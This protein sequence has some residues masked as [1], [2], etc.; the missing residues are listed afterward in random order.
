MKMFTKILIAV[1]IIIAIPM[2]M[3]LF[4]KNQYTVE[5]EI[6]IN[7]PTP[8]VFDY[9]KH[10]KNQDNY[11]KWVRM[12]PNMTKAFAGT[13]G[14]VGF[15]YAWE[16]PKAGK[17]EQELK[18]ITEGQRVDMEL[19]FKKPFESIATAYMTTEP[20][21]ASHTKVKWQMAGTSKYPMN[22]MNLF[23]DKLLG[24]DLQTSLDMLKNNLEKQQLTG[25]IK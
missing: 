13:D 9:I 11:N 10:L 6:T 14:T 18:R 16:G 5:R 23:M 7:K 20:L 4:I 19:R 3:A 12:D 2:I 15:I 8:E 22:I 25:N 21:A 1:I 24:T 17:G